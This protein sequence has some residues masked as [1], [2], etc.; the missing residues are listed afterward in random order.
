MKENSHD[1]TKRV[2]VKSGT[3]IAAAAFA[4][5]LGGA[6]K[7]PMP[8]RG[9]PPAGATEE[10]GRTRTMFAQPVMKAI[11]LGINAPNSH[12]TQA[13]KFRVLDDFEMQLYVDEKRLL[14][15][16]DPPA[17]QI[18]IERRLFPGDDGAG[19]DAVWVR[20]GGRP[21]PRGVFVRAWISA[22]SRWRRSP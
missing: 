11:A 19:G 6:G 4:G 22:A 12:N 10:N 21:F 18:H 16:T 9:N 1:D 13:W 15:A 5:A 2:L 7:S 8:T 14:P 20:S 3:V 17:R